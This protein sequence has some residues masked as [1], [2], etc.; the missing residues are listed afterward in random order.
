MR[1]ILNACLVVL[2]AATAAFAQAPVGTISG[3][4]RDQT[5]AVLPGASITIRHAAT[6]AER[7]VTSADDGTFAAPSLPAGAYTVTAELTGFRTHRER[8]DGRDRAGGHRRYAHGAW[9][10]DRSRHRR[11]QRHPRRNRSARRHAA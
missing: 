3:T 11:R 5:N 4:V 2:L 6:G 10:G 1:S 9:G 7:H 8:S